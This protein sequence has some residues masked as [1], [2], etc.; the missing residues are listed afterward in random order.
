MSFIFVSK[1]F[2]LNIGIN[3]L[4]GAPANVSL[5]WKSILRKKEKTVTFSTGNS[6]VVSEWHALFVFTWLL[7]LLASFFIVCNVTW[8]EM[9]RTETKMVSPEMVCNSMDVCVCVCVNILRCTNNH[10]AHVHSFRAWN[11]VHSSRTIPLIAEIV[12][13]TMHLIAFKAS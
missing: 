6:V 7:L 3:Q 13:C 11:E 12:K 10:C 8:N 9:C 5:C 2:V 1:T 4:L